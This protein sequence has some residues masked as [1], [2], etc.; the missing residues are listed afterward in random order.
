MHIICIYAH[1]SLCTCLSHARAHAQRARSVWHAAGWRRERQRISSATRFAS[2]LHAASACT[3]LYGTLSAQHQAPAADSAHRHSSTMCGIDTAIVP[4]A[5]TMVSLAARWQQWG[6][7]RRSPWPGRRRR[8]LVHPQPLPEALTLLP[9]VP[10]STV[11]DRRA[12]SVSA[13][14]IDAIDVRSSCR[15]TVG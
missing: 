15:L 6:R 1:V 4:L 11:G 14:P 3:L 8:Q 9:T 5:L 7:R 13:M 2:G 12:W 10:W